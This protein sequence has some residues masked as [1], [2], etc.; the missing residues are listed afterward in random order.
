MLC[1]RESIEERKGVD[2]FYQV[3]A[4]G[5]NKYCVMG[6]PV[7]CPQC[8]MAPFSVLV[9]HYR[10]SE[11]R[12]SFFELAKFVHQIKIKCLGNFE[13]AEGE[14]AVCLPCEHQE[15]PVIPLHPRVLD[16]ISGKYSLFMLCRTRRKKPPITRKSSR[17]KST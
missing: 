2:V 3:S 6:M 9:P 17:I 7:T 12:I 5:S 16:G 8:P 4:S 10:L 11:D 1:S 14:G 13:N 15:L